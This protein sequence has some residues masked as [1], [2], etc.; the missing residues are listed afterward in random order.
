M[1]TLCKHLTRKIPNDSRLPT[2]YKKNLYGPSLQLFNEISLLNKTE[3]WKTDMRNQ[4]ILQYIQYINFS[5]SVRTHISSLMYQNLIYIKFNEAAH[6][7]NFSQSRIVRLYVSIASV[8]S[9]LLKWIFASSRSPLK[10]SVVVLSKPGKL[11]MSNKFRTGSSMKL[12]SD[13]SASGSCALNKK[14]CRNSR[15]WMILLSYIFWISFK[16][17]TFNWF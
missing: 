6:P 7:H 17:F 2:I 12:L 10:T 13:C 1:K 3:I 14:N 9:L 4:I 11:P 5:T 8:Y 16:S 15:K